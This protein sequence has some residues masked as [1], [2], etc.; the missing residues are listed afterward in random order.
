M[1]LDPVSKTFEF[2]TTTGNVHAVDVLIYALDAA[3]EAVRE[4]AGVALLRRAA[5]RGQ[6]EVIR[7]YDRLPERVR[8]MLRE[9]QPGRLTGALRHALCYGDEQLRGFGRK[10]LLDAEY[11][12]Q[13]PL[14]LEMIESDHLEQ[15]E[16]GASLLREL[17]GRLYEH[18]HGD[19]EA[20]KG[21]GDEKDGSKAGRSAA[22]MGRAVLAHLENAI[23]KY[24]KLKRPA[25]IVEAALSLGCIEHESARKILNQSALGCRELAGNLLM[26]SRDP[27]VMRLVLDLMARSYPPLRVFAVLQER[28]DIEFITHILKSYPRNPGETLVKNI[29]QVESVAWLRDQETLDAIPQELH[30]SLVSFV[31]STGIPH[32]AKTAL[33][34]WII[35]NG[36]SEGRLAS[37]EALSVLD[38]RAVKT[39]LYE[40]LESPDEVAQAWATSQLRSR[41][42]PEALRLLIERLDSPH[43]AVRAAA[44]EELHSFNLELMLGLF[45]QVD[46][47]LAHRAGEL[48]RK[49]D[50]DYVERLK[51][52]LS[53]PIARKRM[54][55]ARGAVAL[56]MADDVADAIIA[57]AEDE[58][59]LV[60]RTIAEILPEMKHDGILAVLD[61]LRDD[62]NS[63]VREGAE[64]AI[65]RIAGS[66]SS[67]AE[68][69]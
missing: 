14:L 57:L 54:H 39:A 15:S 27:G 23:A 6:T 12:D 55:A 25:P 48:V 53:G 31:S 18:L 20:R 51:A 67:M 28:S 47:S 59:A 66:R 34:Q 35:R 26:T 41:G 68:S 62:P 42:I 32:A 19:K 10:L 64:E 56:G 58:D 46:A 45:D 11:Y 16:F 9:Q 43:E 4:R 33:H 13:A 65:E 29:R 30:E 7:R 8:G 21:N 22:K 60:R 69:A 40:N 49:I 5:T 3:D 1:V 38:D 44:R 50:H 2:L 17:V 63:R 37:A 24:E 52:E 36:S 61:R